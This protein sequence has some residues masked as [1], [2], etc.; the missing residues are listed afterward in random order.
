MHLQF[1]HGELFLQTFHQAGGDA[2]IQFVQLVVQPVERLPGVAGIGLRIGHAQ[3][4]LEPVPMSVG[5]IRQD[6]ANLVHLTAW[7]EGSLAG[8]PLNGR[9]QSTASV[10][11]IQARLTEVES[12]LG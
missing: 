7:E 1:M 9:P 11:Q 8:M 10:Q 3:L 12:A 5:Q 2:R 6:V 4:V